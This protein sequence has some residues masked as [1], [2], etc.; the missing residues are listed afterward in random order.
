MHP[1]TAA[2]AK[3]RTAIRLHW[4]ISLLSQLRCFYCGVIQAL[5]FVIA[6]KA[7]Q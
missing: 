5:S 1:A 6:W 7:G 2:N 4:L 3:R